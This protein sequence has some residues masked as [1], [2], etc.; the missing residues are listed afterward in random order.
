MLDII[1]INNKKYVKKTVN[2]ISVFYHLKTLNLSSVPP[3]LKIEGNMVY[4]EYI[5]GESLY[6]LINNKTLNQ[7]ERV[8]IGLQL[9]IC[10]KEINDN[11]IIH[12]DLKPENIIIDKNY[13]VFLIDF[14]ASRLYDDENKNRDTQLFGTR[15]YA[16]PEHYGYA[17]TTHKSD[18]YSLGKVLKDL[19]LPSNYNDLINKC[20]EINPNDRFSD[21][22]ILLE[23]YEKIMSGKHL[24]TVKQKI[25]NM[26]INFFKQE[27][28]YN[29]DKSFVQRVVL[30]VLTLFYIQIII[31]GYSDGTFKN[32][33]FLINILVLF[34]MIASSAYIFDLIRISFS[35]KKRGSDYKKYIKQFIINILTFY[36]ILFI[37]GSIAYFLGYR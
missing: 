20:T 6:D 2:N 7:R 11:Y 36:I 26:F 15:G 19:D 9:I 25:N 30:I 17:Q 1:K 5:N 34:I 21:Y 28:G 12:K 23:S 13:Q 31:S 29:Y 37:F 32:D 27:Y 10:L 14:G 24:V 33:E 35:A 4:Y 8:I 16:S 18:I 22:D 3:I